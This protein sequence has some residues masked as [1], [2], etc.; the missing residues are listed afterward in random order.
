[1]DR[2]EEEKAI[3]RLTDILKGYGIDVSYEEIK[4]LESESIRK[5]VKEGP[6]DR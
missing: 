2:I 4:E 6:G 3:N 5:K 1:M